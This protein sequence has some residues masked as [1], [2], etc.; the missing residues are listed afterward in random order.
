MRLA[1]LAALLTACACTMQRDVPAPVRYIATNHPNAI[2]VQSPDKTVRV[3]NPHVDGNTILGLQDGRPFS[4]PASDMT[5]VSVRR[6]LLR[7]LSLRHRPPRL[8]LI[9]DGAVPPQ[10]TGGKGYNEIAACHRLD[11]RRHL[12]NEWSSSAIGG[13]LG[14]CDPFGIPSTSRWTGAVIIV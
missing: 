12:R 2:W 4:V 6:R 11:S 10:P 14:R 9:I 8:R 5:V 13:T 3:D 7:P 1:I